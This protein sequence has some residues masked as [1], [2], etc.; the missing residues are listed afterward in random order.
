MHTMILLVALLGQTQTAPSNEITLMMHERFAYATMMR[1]AVI[2]GYLDRAMR[3]AR[4]LNFALEEMS[5][6]RIRQLAEAASKATT[7]A[8]AAQGIARVAEACGDCHE[9]NKINVVVMGYQAPPLGQ[10]LRARMGR[11]IWAADRMWEGL[12][13]HSE[14]SWVRGS[15]ALAQDPFFTPDDEIRVPEEKLD[16]LSSIAAEGEAAK[17]WTKRAEV[18]G[19]FL[20]ACADCHETYTH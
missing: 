3:H 17:R 8:E 20:G 13:A 18:Y 19:R 5:T 12:V 2:H 15:K 1:T 6:V 14:S 16:E 9:E 11:H 10:D 7:L 4:Q